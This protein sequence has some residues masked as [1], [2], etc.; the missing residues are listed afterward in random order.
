ML[1]KRVVVIGRWSDPSSHTLE[2]QDFVRNGE[3]FIPLFSDE[4]HFDRETMGSGFESEGI[5]ID[6]DFFVSLL[7][8]D[9]LLILN[10]G[11]TSPTRLR[12]SDLT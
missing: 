3:T 7:R 8:G 9:E 5:S 10:P 2:L 11:S 1:G 12:K 4:D 6:T